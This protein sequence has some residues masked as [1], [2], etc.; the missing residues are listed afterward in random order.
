MLQ[1]LEQMRMS[2][3]YRGPEIELRFHPYSQEEVAL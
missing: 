2:Y 3:L 1:S